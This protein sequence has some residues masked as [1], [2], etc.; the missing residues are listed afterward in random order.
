MK[1]KKDCFRYNKEKICLDVKECGFFERFRGLMF[2]K[3]NFS[4]ILLFDFKKPVGYSIHSWFVFFDFLAVWIDENDNVI[5]IK[6]VKPFVF[7]I[8]PKQKFSR[9]IEI[10]FSDKNKKTIQ[11]LVEE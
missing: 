6:R 11:K 10:P 8:K 1:N 5:E 4:D 2:R 3:K 7:R 9:L